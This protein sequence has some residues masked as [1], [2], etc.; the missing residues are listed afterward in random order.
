MMD[1]HIYY[2]YIPLR[3]SSILSVLSIV[4]DCK[5]KFSNYIKITNVT[6]CYFNI[7]GLHKH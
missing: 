3:K 4:D 7:L 6:L 5:L 2:F 1:I